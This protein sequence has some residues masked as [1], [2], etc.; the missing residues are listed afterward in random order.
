MCVCG[1]GVML[2]S[3]W[4]SSQI[5]RNQALGPGTVSVSV[6]PCCRPFL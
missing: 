4:G 1:G 5:E 6:F 3:Y 2:G